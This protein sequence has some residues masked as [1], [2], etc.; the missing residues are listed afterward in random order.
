[1]VVLVAMY[2]G[3]VLVSPWSVICSGRPNFNVLKPTVRAGEVL[4]Q[5]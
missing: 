2:L 1:M 3:S 5:T 4:L